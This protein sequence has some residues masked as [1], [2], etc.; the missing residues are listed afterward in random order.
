MDGYL[1]KPF[2][3]DALLQVL[4]SCFS[5]AAPAVAPAASLDA[6]AVDAILDQGA[7]GR[8]RALHRPGGPNLLAKVLG[9]YSSS[10][11]ALI[12]T[13][14]AAAEAQDAEGLRQAA[15]AL[16]SSS[17]NVG[18]LAFAEQCKNPGSRCRRRQARR[19]RVCCSMSCSPATHAC[20]RRSP[21][22]TWR[23]EV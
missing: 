17:A 10:S 7:L 12:D 9:L 1:S 15:H 22:K 11:A 5:D 2:T 3:S 21:R 16:K 19:G 18:A 20:C 14:R 8:I 4:E 6:R 23:P 13:L